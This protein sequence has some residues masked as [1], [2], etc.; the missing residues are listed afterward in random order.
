MSAPYQ[1]S[2][3]KGRMVQLGVCF[4]LIQVLL[5]GAGIATGVLVAPGALKL[6][7]K[8]PLSQ[9]IAEKGGAS[10]KGES[11]AMGEKPATAAAGQPDAVKE[12]EQAQA[13]SPATPAAQ[14]ASSTQAPAAATQQAMANAAPAP[15]EMQLDSHLSVQVASFHDKDNALRLADVLKRQG[16][17]KVTVGQ[18][19]SRNVTWHFVRLGPFRAWEDASRVASE[20][21]RSYDL[22]AYV[23]PAGVDDDN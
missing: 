17:G 2:V 19:D 15:T 6:P 21:D 1:F 18:Y 12:T 8:I 7:D 10:A 23:L 9:A 14:T 22:R 13:S 11:L 5:Y 4:G 16:F 20:L 3:T